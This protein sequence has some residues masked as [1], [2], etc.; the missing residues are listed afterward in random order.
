MGTFYNQVYKPG[1]VLTAIYLGA[2]LLRRSSHLLKAT[3][4]VYCFLHGVAP[5]RVYSIGHFRADG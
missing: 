1:S 3:G 2:A 5:D 4:Q